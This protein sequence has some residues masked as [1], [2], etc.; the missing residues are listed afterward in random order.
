MSSKKEIVFT[1]VSREGET[2]DEHKERNCV[3]TFLTKVGR[4]M[5]LGKFD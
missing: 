2:M 5:N 1:S 3:D 4:W